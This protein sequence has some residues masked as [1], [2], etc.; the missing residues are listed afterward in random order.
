M[1]EWIRTKIRGKS[2]AEIAGNIMNRINTP[3]ILVWI[4]DMIWEHYAAID[5]K[6][7]CL[8]QVM[9][10]TDALETAEEVCKRWLGMQDFG[11]PDPI[12]WAVWGFWL[13]M[14]VIHYQFKNKPYPLGPGK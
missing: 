9:K 1:I 4:G 5:A 6:E 2:Y 12:I 11:I 14:I 7:L 13:L 3:I 10:N 8:L